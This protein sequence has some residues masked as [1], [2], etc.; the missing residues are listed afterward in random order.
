MDAD[1]VIISRDE[2]RLILEPVARAPSLATV[3]AGLRPLD[4]DFGPVEDPPATP[5]EIF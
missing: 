4:L 5:E 1:A 3:L 2:N